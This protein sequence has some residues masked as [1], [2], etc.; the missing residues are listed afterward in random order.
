MNDQILPY[1]ATGAS[2][3]FDEGKSDYKCLDDNSKHYDLHYTAVKFV[4]ICPSV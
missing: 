4:M 1:R 3:H 2:I